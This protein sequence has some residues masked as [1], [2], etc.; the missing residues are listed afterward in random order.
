MDK[1]SAIIVA[2][3]ACVCLA[4]LALIWAL[5]TKDGSN[6]PT[7]SSNNDSDHE[8]EQESGQESQSSELIPSTSSSAGTEANSNLSQ[9]ASQTETQAQSSESQATQTQDSSSQTSHTQSAET[10]STQ[11]HTNPGGYPDDSDI[12]IV[13]VSKNEQMLLNKANRLPDDWEPV[14]LKSIPEGYYVQDGKEYILA[15][16]TLEAFIK[17]ADAAAD[18]GISLKVISAYRSAQYQLGLYNYYVQNHGSEAADTFS[19]RTRHS[20]HETGYAVDINDVNPRFEQTAAFEW[21]NNNAAKYGFILRYPKGKEDITGYMYESWH[22]RYIGKIAT[23]VE[24]SK[25]TYDEY[26]SQHLK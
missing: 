12:A 26:Y 10:T 24:E 16:S 13:D 6:N 17:M 4:I 2:L 19:A 7:Q 25:L 11:I 3:L 8:R 18:D 5:P 23:E 22:W 14:D 9:T 15:A 21:L 1:K 20:E